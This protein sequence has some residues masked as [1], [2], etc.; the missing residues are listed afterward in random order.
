MPDGDWS[1]V[2]QVN[3]LTDKYYHYQVLRG[4]VNSQTRVAAPR[5]WM[6]TLRR[7]F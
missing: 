1:A 7:D 3:N 6:L 5:E 4:S 2:L